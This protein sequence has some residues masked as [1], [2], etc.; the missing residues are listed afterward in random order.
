M[1]KDQID[2]AELLWKR[3]KNKID[4]QMTPDFEDL[5]RGVMHIIYAEYIRMLDEWTDETKRQFEEAIS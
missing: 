1:N 4:E 3:V 2:G 5:L